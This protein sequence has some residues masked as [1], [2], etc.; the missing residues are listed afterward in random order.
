MTEIQDFDPD[1]IAAFI[2][3]R[4]SGAE[5]ERM[6]RLL[7]ESE[8]A[9]EVYSGAVMARGD[10]EE[11]AFA[12]GPS[13]TAFEAL[14]DCRGSCRRRCRAADRGA[15]ADPGKR[16]NATLAMRAESIAQPLTG[17]PQLAMALGSTWDE[18]R[19]P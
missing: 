2:D 10:L 14:V 9:F 11:D 4:L 5:R 3:G 18:G 12:R 17:R 15:P 7:A 16:A 13:G 1:S 19:G 6:V 8:A